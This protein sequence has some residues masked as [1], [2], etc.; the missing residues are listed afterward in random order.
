[1]SAIT[2]DNP[3]GKTGFYSFWST[4]GLGIDKAVNEA[5]ENIDSKEFLTENKFDIVKW[6][7]STV[8]KAFDKIKEVFNN[9]KSNLVK[10]WKNTFD[11]LDIEVDTGNMNPVINW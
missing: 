5:I 7:K 1:M 9:I 6:F 2:P 4:V 3:K 11:Y 8:K 10:S